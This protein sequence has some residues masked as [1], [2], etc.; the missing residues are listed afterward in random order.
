MAKNYVQEG[1]YLWLNVGS[2]VKSGDPVAVGDIAGVAT[3]DADANGYATIDTEGVYNLSVKGTTGSNSA[4][5]IGD[6]IYYVTGDTPKL[7]K[8]N[9]GVAFGHAL[10]AIDA[11]ATAT[12]PVKITTK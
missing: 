2:G 9:T 3:I 1:R 10:G 5:A 7:D 11:G 6:I 8:K 12:I 4:V